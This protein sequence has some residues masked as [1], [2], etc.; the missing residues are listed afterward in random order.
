MQSHAA[1]ALQYGIERDFAGR[2]ENVLLYDV[3][4]SDVVAAL[5]EYS[6]YNVSGPTKHLSQ[7][8][9]KDIA[10]QEGSGAG[11][12]DA[13]LMEHVA[14]EFEAQ[15]DVKN[16]LDSSKVAAKLRRAVRRT[17][18]MLSA[19]SQAPCNVEELHGGIDLSTTVTRS[20]LEE[21]AGEQS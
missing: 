17:K 7:F 8:A 9:V 4:S 12:L 18:E 11:R 2:T 20:K 16:I 15:N 21:L 14:A 6:S 10:W 1:A 3:S 5:V 13:L 19:N